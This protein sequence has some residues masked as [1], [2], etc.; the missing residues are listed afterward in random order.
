MIEDERIEF[1]NSRDETHGRYV[2]YWMQ[3]SQRV[4]FNH[5]LEYAAQRANASGL[6]VVVCFGL[7]DA[8]PEANLRHYTF[9]LEGLREVARDLE[10]RRIRFVP[11]RGSPEKVVTEMAKDAALV[12]TDRGYLHIQK[13]WRRHV[14][15]H[16]PCQVVQVESDVVVPVETASNKEEYAA[17][18]IRPK[19]MKQVD[20]F[21]RPLGTTRVRKN[22]LGMRFDTLDLSH[23]DLDV[24]RSVGRVSAYIGGASEAKRLLDDFIRSKLDRCDAKRSDPSADFESHMSPYLHF[25]QISPVE[26]ALRVKNARARG[27]AKDVFLEELIVRRE[28]SVNFVHNNRRY[29]SYR[30]LP[31]WARTTLRRHASDKRDYIYSRRQMEEARTHDRYWNAAMHEMRLTGKMHNTMRMYWGKKILEWSPTPEVAFRRT[32]YLNNKYFL[33]GRDPNSF[34]GVAWCFGKHDRPWA[35]RDV[36]GTVRYMNAK[37]LERK[38][39]IDVYVCRIDALARTLTRKGDA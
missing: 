3:A 22:S 27:A 24:D 38:F 31:G 20:R 8:F 6:P 4:R 19:I 13:Q 12:V 26:I 23:L 7:T 2:L 39:D 33:D 25:G 9:M 34:T 10:A 17:R 11:R 28:L 21:L 35:E 32:L 15:R 1:M 14:A 29:H 36:F 37:G 18:T 16:A 5:A 30:A